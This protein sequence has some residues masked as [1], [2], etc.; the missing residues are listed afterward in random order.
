MASTAFHERLRIQELAQAGQTDRQIA[1]AL[2]WKRATIRKW[3]RLGQ[4]AGPAA[5]AS[6]MGRPPTGVLSTFAPMVGQK[7]AAWRQG[8]PGWGPKTLRAQLEQD[9]TLVGVPLP[10]RATL[11]RW[12]KAHGW[13]RAYQKH[14]PLPQPSPG[15]AHAPHELW[16]MDACGYQTLP[17]VG[18]VALIALHDVVSRAKLMSFP[19]W[20][21]DTRPQRL[22]TTA[23]Y[24]AVLRLTF[25]GWGLPDQLGVDR[26]AIFHENGSASPFPTRLHLWLVALGVEVVFGRPHCPT[27]QAIAE[28]G[29][30][31]WEA[32]V[33]RGQTFRN[34]ETLYQVLQRRRTFLNEVL[35]CA[36]LG[37]RPPLVA[38][39]QARQPRRPYQPQWE[40]D[41]LDLHRI[42]A[43]LSQG[44]WF[45]KVCATGT[46]V[47]GGQ[48]YGL[49]Q[50]GWPRQEVCIT[51]DPSDRHLIFETPGVPV[52]KRLPLRGVT[53]DT[54]MGELGP[55][56][57][58]TAFQFSLPFSWE[59]MRAVR[60]A[61]TLGGTTL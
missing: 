40:A 25:A 5:L 31:T 32:Q 44:R 2:G 52:P 43:Y 21:G 46:L 23:D 8:H 4:R 53:P 57:H 55:L 3:R 41:L 19:C 26:D 7:L 42:D 20:L 1:D 14:V 56:V 45:R 50:Q 35:P 47:L 59:E 38:F 34:W 48:T 27:D 58:L 15:P 54:L 24:Q 11:G 10:S 16:Q 61:E 29:H 13:T 33:L 22:A 37:E 39:P 51:F 60:L 9:P 17:G 49:G 30:Q 36:S 28:R 18:V 12:L 6:A